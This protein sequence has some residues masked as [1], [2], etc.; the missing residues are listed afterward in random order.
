MP[1][2]VATYT[3][4]GLQAYLNRLGQVNPTLSLIDTFKVGEGGFKVEAL[5]N[6]PRVPDPTLTDLDIIV[7][8]SRY[9]VNPT[10]TF[11]KALGP[12]DFAVTPSDNGGVLEATC[13]LDFAEYNNDGA[14]NF[15]QI[16]EIGLFAGSLMVAYGTFN[17]Q[18][19]DPGSQIPFTVAL[20]AEAP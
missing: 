15:P 1:T 4:A 11:Q 14:G 12:G 17:E 6:V 8:P 7:N 13:L 18:G 5:G 16:Y 9:V 3:A 10:P 20:T 19:K 2:V